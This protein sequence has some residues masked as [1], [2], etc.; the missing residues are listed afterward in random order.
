LP[1]SLPSISLTIKSI[2]P[3]SISLSWTG[4]LNA[5]EYY[6]EKRINSQPFDKLIQTSGLTYLDDNLKSNT[7]YEYRL[8]Y[9]TEGGISKKS[10][11]SAKT[12]MVLGTNSDFTPLLIFP[13]PL[14]YYLF[15]KWMKAFSGTIQL[16]ST[17]GSIL[18]EWNYSNCFNAELDIRK[19]N[20]G[21]YFI[22]V[23]DY[24]GESK[25]INKILILN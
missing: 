25:S 23:L 17:N 14:K 16:I 7:I 4:A 2:S 13:N 12:T 21:A 6:L 15:I 18:E 11:V 3:N 9:I 5:K 19:Y 8:Y 24:N 10:F 1:D 22:N 20:A